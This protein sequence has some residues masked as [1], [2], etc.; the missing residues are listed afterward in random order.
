MSD[1][2]CSY[3]DREAVLMAYLYDEIT[4]GDREAFDIHLTTCARCRVELNG[5][6]GVRAQLLHWAPPD[7]RDRPAVT[8][9]D[10]GRPRRQLLTVGEPRAPIAIDEQRSSSNERR[11]SSH[12]QR[13]SSDQRRRPWRDIPAWAQG[14]AAMLILGVSA[15]AANLNIHYDGQ[16][17]LNVRTGWSHP[18]QPVAQA[19]AAQPTDTATRT[20]LAALERQLRSEIQAASPTAPETR[21]VSASNVDAHRVKMLLDESERRH[22]REMALKIAE[23][24]RDFNVQRQSDLVKIDQ[25]LGLIDRRNDIEVRKNRQMIDMYLQRVSQR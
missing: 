24:I 25:N 5:L 3:K 10:I 4:A 14:T 9:E 21:A 8:G 1:I 23:V 2:L 15:G 22:E 12:E 17:G 6:S 19:P 11:V 20:E 16:S 7:Y 13:V 18:A